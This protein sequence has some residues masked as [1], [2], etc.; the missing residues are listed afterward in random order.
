[1]DP[2]RC[3]DC[4]KCEYEHRTW[5]FSIFKDELSGDDTKNCDA[6]VPESS[7]DQC[8]IL[9]ASP[10]WELTDLEHIFPT[11]TEGNSTP[12]NGGG[13]LAF[14]LHATPITG[15][16]SCC[17]KKIFSVL[18]RSLVYVP[19]VNIDKVIMDQNNCSLLLLPET[20]GLRLLL[21]RP[22]EKKAVT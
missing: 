13:K 8:V 19:I 9:S 5:V 3:G 10:V 16:R 1:M 18:K 14:K 4:S 7:R 21:R 2:N 11:V 6:H 20:R 15:C 17:E 22:G 12:S